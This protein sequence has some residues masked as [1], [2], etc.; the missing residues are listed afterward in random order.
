MR[1]IRGTGILSAL[2]VSVV[3]VSAGFQQHVVLLLQVVLSA[4]DEYCNGFAEAAE[5]L[6]Q[7]RQA[8]ICRTFRYLPGTG[9]EQ[10]SNASYEYRYRLR[11]GRGRPCNMHDIITTQSRHLN[12]YNSDYEYGECGTYKK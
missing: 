11:V 1:T 12:E 8:A 2:P 6:F 5:C 9:S 4:D 7:H 3:R 10:L